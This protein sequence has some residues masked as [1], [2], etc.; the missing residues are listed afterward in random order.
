MKSE[1]K[2]TFQI[3]SESKRRFA[4]SDRA[5]VGH[6]PTIALTPVVDGRT[7]AYEDNAAKTWLLVEKV[8]EL[9][10]RNVALPDGTPVRLVMAPEIV[11]GARTGALAQQYYTKQGVTAN[12]WISRSW[13]YS[14]ELM[15]ACQGIGSSEWQQ[16]AYG[17]NQTDRP[18]AV[19]LKAFTA[20]MDEKMRPIFSIYNPDL[21]DETEPFSPYIEERLLRFARCAAA[22]AEIRGKNYLSIGSVSMGIVGSDARRNIMLDYLGMGRSNRI[23]VDAKK[24]LRKIIEVRHRVLWQRERIRIV[25]IKPLGRNIKRN[26]RAKESD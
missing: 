3:R 5:L 14:D 24:I 4:K 22:V 9:I 12:I 26:M 13:A 6:V 16:A 1:P 25:K 21:E 11:Y 20:A 7:G 8:H 10:S 2:S 19:W 15:S 23:V 18:G 17:L